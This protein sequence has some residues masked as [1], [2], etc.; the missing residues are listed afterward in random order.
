MTEKQFNKRILLIRTA[1]VNYLNKKDKFLDDRC[2]EY[3]KQLYKSSIKIA[4]KA[5]N[6]YYSYKTK[7][8]RKKSFKDVCR[9]HMDKKN[10]TFNVDYDFSSVEEAHGYKADYLLKYMYGINPSDQS[11]SNVG[12][13]H[14][15][16]IAGYNHPHP[17]TPWVRRGVPDP[18]SPY[19]AKF[20]TGDYWLKK[21][22][23]DNMSIREKIENNIDEE[24]DKLNKKFQNN[25]DFFCQKNLKNIVKMI[26][27]LKKDYYGGE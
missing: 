4:K 20:I 24:F 16:D 5:V 18:T 6:D 23:K 11:V 10:K 21:A 2:T 15:G 9:I 27:D 1:F 22:S 26:S 13:W 8:R 19:G 17:G 25:Y 12:G 7:Y 3:L 14:G